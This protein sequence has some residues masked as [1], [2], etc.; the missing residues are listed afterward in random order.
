MEQ[1]K[2]KDHWPIFIFFIIINLLAIVFKTK[3][4]AKNIDADVIIAAN[5]LLLLL[6]ISGLW[7]HNRALKNPNPNVAIRAVMGA[8]ALKLFILALAVIIYIIA[9]G[10][11]R[12]IKAI[13]VC[14]GLYIV[15]TFFETKI[16]MK[17]KKENNAN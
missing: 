13:F 11:D 8:T 17:M 16:S 5:V 6:S 12:S 14:M 3:L 15:Y 2:S 10:K 4:A 7:M 9:A 1:K